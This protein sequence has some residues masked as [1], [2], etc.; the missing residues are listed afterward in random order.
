M[1]WLYRK[2]L[3]RDSQIDKLRFDID[4]QKDFAILTNEITKAW[5]GKT[6]KDYK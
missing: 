3:V 1:L 5:S 6:V 4:K 2:N